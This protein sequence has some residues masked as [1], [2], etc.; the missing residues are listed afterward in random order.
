MR[1]RFGPARNVESRT[2]EFGRSRWVESRIGY[3]GQGGLREASRVGSWSVQVRRSWVVKAGS[4]GV[5]HCGR[6]GDRSG[7][8]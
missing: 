5:S 3:A 1:S 7:P 8:D 6:V 4:V 2:V